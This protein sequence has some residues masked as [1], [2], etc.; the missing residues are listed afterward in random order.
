MKHVFK[1]SSFEFQ[2]LFSCFNSYGSMYAVNEKYSFG[3]FNSIMFDQIQ[4]I[5]LS[6]INRGSAGHAKAQK[7]YTLRFNDT[8]LFAVYCVVK[9]NLERFNESKDA[10]I[11][12]RIEKSLPGNLDKKFSLAY[13]LLRVNTHDNEHKEP[14]YT[15]RNL[16][17]IPAA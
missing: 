7:S 3:L 14:V 13:T 5:Y 4:K 6:L 17:Q 2:Q 9:F 15:E 16:R 8:E 10:L 12:M 11:F 1:L